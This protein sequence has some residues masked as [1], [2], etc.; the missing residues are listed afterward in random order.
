MEGL[1]VLID[2]DEYSIE[3]SGKIVGILLEMSAQN[4]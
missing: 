1:D 2:L 3:D 4:A